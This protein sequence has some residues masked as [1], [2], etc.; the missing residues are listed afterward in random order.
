MATSGTYT[1]SVTATQMVSAI[2]RALGVLDLDE[3]PT[4]NESSAVIQAINFWMFQKKAP[5]FHLNPGSMMWTR[6]TADLTLAAK[7]SYD[8][9]PSGGDCDIQIPVQILTATLKDTDANE[10][11]LSFMSLEDYQTLPKKND[12]GTPTRIYYE[13][14]ID[15]GKL[16]LDYIPSD[17]TDVIDFV[18]RQPLEII[19]AGA[20]EFDIEDYWYRAIRFGVALDVA[21]DFNVNNAMVLQR[22]KG[23]YD[24]AMRHVGAFFPEDDFQHFQPGI[25]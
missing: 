11:P 15:T 14:R 21:G 16:Y 23:L 12:T 10:T 5:P 4:A 8:L 20:N 1:L 9:K 24:D 6:E 13:K 3:S 25:D 17:T 19:S 18:Y 2:M 22:C 7:A